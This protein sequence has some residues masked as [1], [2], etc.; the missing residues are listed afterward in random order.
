MNLY[1]IISYPLITEKSALDAEKQHKYSFRVH[2]A[3]T[4]VEIRQAVEKVFNVKVIKINTSNVRGKL[5]RVRYQP[6]Y[7]A[8]W[9]KAVVTLKSGQKIDFAQ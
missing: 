5:K 6:G 4:K 1:D 3:A 7:T 9:K 8:A 2:P